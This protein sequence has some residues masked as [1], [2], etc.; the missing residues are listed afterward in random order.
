MEGGGECMARRLKKYPLVA[1]DRRRDKA[2]RAKKPGKRRSKRGRVYSERRPN[3]SD[4]NP[5]RRL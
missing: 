1:K 4:R 2:R 5:K 3:R